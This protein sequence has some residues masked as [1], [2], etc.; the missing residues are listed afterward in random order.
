[1][2]VLRRWSCAKTWNGLPPC[3]WCLPVHD[4]DEDNKC[5]NDNSCDRTTI[6]T[7]SP[8]W[9]D[10]G[11]VDTA[12]RS[13]RLCLAGWHLRQ[14]C[15]AIV[16]DRW[17]ECRVTFVLSFGVLIVLGLGDW[18]SS[19]HVG[20]TM[21]VW[22]M[23]HFANL[24]LFQRQGCVLISGCVPAWAKRPLCARRSPIIPKMRRRARKRRDTIKSL[25]RAVKPWN[26][27]CTWLWQALKCHCD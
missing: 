1:M 26:K 19:I 9:Y 14:S 18:H 16:L 15:L 4:I 24:K 23:P 27:N 25:R 7:L 11:T 8:P 22:W 13:C 12:R 6:T 3:R 21:I 20:T 10:G 17:V 5:D 2:Y